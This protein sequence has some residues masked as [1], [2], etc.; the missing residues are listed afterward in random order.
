MKK[1]IGAN[2]KNILV[3]IDH[4]G[5]KGCEQIGVLRAAPVR[6]REVFSFAGNKNW[7]SR[8]ELKMFDPDLMPFE[9]PQYVRDE[10]PNFG[11]FLDSS[12]DR[13]GRLLM[14]RREALVARREG[15]P[16]NILNESDFLLGVYDGNRMGALRLKLSEDGDFLDNNRELAA[17]PF[18]SGRELEYAS[19]QIEK[20]PLDDDEYAKW[21]FMLFNPGS[22][23]GGARP[24]ANIFKDNNLWI[25]KFPAANDTKDMGAWERVLHI[26]AGDAGIWTAET[27][28]HRLSERGT[29]FFS[30]RFDRSA[31]AKRIHFASAMT[32]LGKVDGADSASG[33]SYLDIA[34]II[35][36]HGIRVNDNL[37]QLWRRVV[38]N[39]A[40]SNC[41]DHLRN[42]G[43][44]L[45]EGGWELSPA[46]DMNPDENG[47]GLSLNISGFDNALDFELAVEVSPYFRL[48]KTKARSIVNDVGHSVAKWRKTA[49][50]SGLP[51][52]EQ[53][54]V[55]PAFRH[56]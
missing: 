39:I 34:G 32:L 5:W 51:R 16:V 56:V 14:R 12:P 25:A 9:G 8:K 18:S 50:N 46:Y 53:E 7:L 2:E 42:H 13:W 4:A 21:L 28:A 43:F 24:K 44:I 26:L 3:Y 11:L 55:A 54:R 31:D 15:R 35:I 1:S 41:D 23:L 20:R 27:E 37:E 10:K 22:S 6:G 19:A 30:K 52:S 47:R 36:R 33:T 40:V 29:T 48:S 45:H 38:F 49:E 17:P